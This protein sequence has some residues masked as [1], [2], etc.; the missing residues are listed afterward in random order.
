MTSW[1]DSR[2]NFRAIIS[3]RCHRLP[4]KHVESKV[5]GWLATI[6]ERDL[7]CVMHIDSQSRG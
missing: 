6:I 5:T 1:A 2:H 4:M 3:C 7:S